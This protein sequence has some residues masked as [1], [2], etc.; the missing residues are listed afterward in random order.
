MYLRPRPSAPAKSISAAPFIACP[1]RW[2]IS[3]PLADVGLDTLGVALVFENQLAALRGA[4]R[5]GALQ[6]VVVGGSGLGAGRLAGRQGQAQGHES[7]RELHP[8][9]PKAPGA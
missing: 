1:I 8:I 4:V 3:G 2:N 6:G 9:I 7:K 5:R